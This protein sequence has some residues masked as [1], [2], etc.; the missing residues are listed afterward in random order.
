[1]KLLLNRDEGKDFLRKN[2]RTFP[3]YEVESIEFT[4]YGANMEI[5]L[6]EIVPEEKIQTLPAPVPVP[7][8]FDQEPM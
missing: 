8:Q 3:G 6:K 4:S 2:L 1:M 5:E 7:K